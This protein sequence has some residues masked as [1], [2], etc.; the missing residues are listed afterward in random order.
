[1]SGFEKLSGNMGGLHEADLKH[2]KLWPPLAE[3]RRRGER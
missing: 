2:P 3:N 1:L